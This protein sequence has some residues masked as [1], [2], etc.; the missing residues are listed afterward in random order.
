MVQS[1]SQ[2]QMNRRIGSESSCTIDKNS[3]SGHTLCNSNLL[4]KTGGNLLHP[5]SAW[6]RRDQPRL[7]VSGW[8]GGGG[9]GK[10][11]RDQCPPSVSTSATALLYSL[12]PPTPSLRQLPPICRF[13]LSSGFEGGGGHTVASRTGLL[14]DETRIPCRTLVACLVER[15]M[16]LAL[17]EN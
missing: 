10:S 12:V 13:L 11:A 3:H 14:P 1:V 9:D 15:Q 6:L 8:G 7:I 17:A 4:T 2:S 16:A 5:V